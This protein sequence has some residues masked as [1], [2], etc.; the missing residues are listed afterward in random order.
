[1]KNK[2]RVFISNHSIFLT[3]E[4]RYDLFACIPIETVGALVFVELENDM[5]AK[6]IKEIFVRYIIDCEP[7]VEPIEIIDQK[8]KLHLPIDMD[9]FMSIQDDAFESFPKSVDLNDILN[10]D[11]G[12]RESMYYETFLHDHTKKI[13]TYHKIEIQDEKYFDESTEFVDFNTHQA[14]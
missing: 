4:Q 14:T 9:N 1:M 6:T 13:K 12:G 7:N 10:K 2:F 11:E 3:E 8:I 5:Q